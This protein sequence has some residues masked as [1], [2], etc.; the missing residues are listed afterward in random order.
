MGSRI[1]I[2]GDSG[3]LG[4]AKDFTALRL[5]DLSFW[6]LTASLVDACASFGFEPIENELPSICAIRVFGEVLPCKLSAKVYSHLHKARKQLRELNEG[7]AKKTNVVGKKFALDD[8]SEIC[9]TVDSLLESVGDGFGMPDKWCAPTPSDVEWVEAFALIS[10]DAQGKSSFAPFQEFGKLQQ[11]A[12][13]AFGC[14]V[15]K[16]RNKK[17]RIQEE[18]D[19][20]SEDDEHRSTLKDEK[21][22]KQDKGKSGNNDKQSCFS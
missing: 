19:E 11:Q 13:K 6:L 3:S 4:F 17:V 1:Q 10:D 14:N 5:A 22:K 7:Y 2:H 16:V 18:L 8:C 15:S 20:E 9:K 21:T 12:A